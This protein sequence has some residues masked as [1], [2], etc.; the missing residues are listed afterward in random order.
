M[1]QKCSRRHVI[2]QMT[3]ESPVPGCICA[4]QI[5]DALGGLDDESVLVGR[6]LTAAI[7][8]LAPQCMHVHRMFHHGVVD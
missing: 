6:E 2:R 8:Q 7:F 1:G 4:N 5:A 3:M